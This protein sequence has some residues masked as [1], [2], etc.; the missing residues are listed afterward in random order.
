M[1]RILHGI[2]KGLR[3]YAEN[4]QTVHI[5]FLFGTGAPAGTSGETAAA[6]IG[7]FYSDNT[8]SAA[9][10]YQKNASTSSASDWVLN[11]T[12][13][14]GIGKWRPER[15]RAVTNDTQGVGV[16]DMTASPFADDNAP[17][18]V[19]GDFVV[20]DFIISDADGTPALLEVTV[21]S[22]P[23][24]TFAAAAS[25]LAAEDTFVAINYLPD[26]AGGENRAIV[27]YNGT[28]LVK[29]GDI[30]WA[31]A[32]GINLSGSYAAS[33]GNVAA[34]DTVE[35][36]IAKL[37]GVNDNQDT[38]L[39]TAQ[40]ATSYASFTGDVIPNTST[41]AGAL[42]ALETELVDT[43]QNVDDLI[44]L[45]GVA[46]NAT[47]NGAYTGT[48]IPDNGTTKQNIQS[49][50]TALELI[51]GDYAATTIT[52]AATVDSMLVDSFAA[53]K[54]LVQAFEEAT[55]GNKKSFEIFAAHNGTTA[56]DATGT[57]RNTIY[58]QLDNG[59]AFNLTITLDLNGAG[60]AQVMRLRAASTSAG[61]TV[62]VKRIAV[63]A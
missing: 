38:L 37:D 7:S 24:V 17:L 26:P 62:K 41:V 11:G 35:V 30:D 44:T 59:S 20:G 10:L 63:I 4:S 57:P 2:E 6:S 58:A 28:I 29:I 55:P 16:R 5:D 14:A 52:A 61:V 60:V 42:Q 40:G 39:G 50:E 43:R 34:S 27:N 15:V 1:S 53:V 48:T 12:S 22:A 13:S 56:A 36:A 54:W 45:S 23:N 18:M 32:T 46:E 8:G 3:I 21:V 25:A 47:N 31:I 49:L 9:K 51:T 33:S 19:A